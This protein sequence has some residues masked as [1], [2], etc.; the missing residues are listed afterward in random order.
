MNNMMIK[1]E[2]YQKRLQE[3]NEEL[4][5]LPAGSLI[6]RGTSYYHYTRRM[7]HRDTG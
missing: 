5:T 2:G 7:S 1:L 4:Q 3:V 6:K